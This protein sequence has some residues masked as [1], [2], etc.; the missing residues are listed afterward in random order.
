MLPIVNARLL[1]SALRANSFP[2][3]EN[4]IAVLA[5]LRDA[6]DVAIEKSEAA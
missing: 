6:I 2:L 4:E 3:T 5:E 1:L